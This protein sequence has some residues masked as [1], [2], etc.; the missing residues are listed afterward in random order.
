[1]NVLL[2]TDYFPPHIGGGVEQV[3]YHI[4]VELVRRGHEVAVVTLNT[5]NASPMENLNGIHVYRAAPIELTNI[6]GIQSSISR[7]VVKLMREV[8]RREQ[9]DVLH[10]NNLYFYTTIAACLNL[11][12]LGIPLVTTL[13]VGSISEL[14]G[15][16]HYAA[17]I[18][19]RSIGRWILRKSN[20]IVAVSQAV[21]RHAETLGMDPC[22]VSV[23][24]NAVDTL[25]FR[26]PSLEDKRDGVV[27]VGFIGRLISNKGA[28]YLV[29]A[30]PH[31]LRDFS[32]VEFQIA[33]DGPMLHELEHRVEQLGIEDAFNFLGTV[34]SN[35]EFIQSCDILVR[36]SLTDGMPLTV[37]EAMACGVPNVATRIGGT[38]EI[39]QDADTG[40]LVQ[41]KSVDELVSRISKLAA[42]A[43]LRT[44]MG[45]R[46]RG[47]IEKYYSWDQA[48]DQLSAIYESVLNS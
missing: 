17:T 33:G 9:S 44:E 11:K 27:R 26:P 5:C 12:S 31:I 24:P 47:F 7:E 15:I 36:P 19:E 8:C 30:A 43:E 6:L 14:D 16:A 41:P 46:A 25:K 40:Y 45:Y 38:P 21:K 32:N 22:K 37:L 13:H 4:A 1:M 42:D 18:Y 35:V 34:R 48:V 39:L 3:T 2:A 28:Q 29:E 20:H 23:I 10:A